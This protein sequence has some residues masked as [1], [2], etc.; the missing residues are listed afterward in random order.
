MKFPFFMERSGM[1]FARTAMTATAALFLSISVAGSAYAQDDDVY[2]AMSG[3]KCLG[4]DINDQV[5]SMNSPC[6]YDYSLS[7][8]EQVGWQVTWHEDNSNLE[9]YDGH[10]WAMKT[11]GDSGKCLTAYWQGQVYLEPCSNPVNYYEQWYEDWNNGYF[12][13]RNRETSQ[14]ITQDMWSQ[15]ITT[16]KCDWS[17][18]DQNLW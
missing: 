13:L 17:N 15:R 2:W 5:L 8:P 4:H 6:H 10:A 11:I 9:A 16:A 7:R 14:C 1:K 12:H 18:D 3:N